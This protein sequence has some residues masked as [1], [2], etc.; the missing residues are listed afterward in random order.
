MEKLS[1]RKRLNI[2]KLY[3]SGLSYRDIAAKVTVSTGAVANVITDL[4]AGNY[5]E[6][7]DVSDQVE[8]LKELA[9]EVTKSGITIGEAMTG[10]TVVSSLKE[11]GLEPTDIPR[12]VSLYKT[13]APTGAET[14][15]FVKAA[16]E[17]EK[18]IQK[19]GL[20]VEDLD[21]KVKSLEEASNRMEPMAAKVLELQ[22]EI[23]QME[24]KKDNLTDEVAEFE[25]RQNVLAASVQEKEQREGDISNRI[26]QLEHRLQSDDERLTIARKDLKTLSE[27]GISL[28]ELSG[29][30]ERLKGVAHRHDIDPKALY[31]RLLTELEQLDKGLKLE[32][33]ILK[34][35]SELHKLEVAISKAEEKLTILS[36]QNQQLRQEIS[37]LKIQ[38]ADERE[39]VSTE[40]EAITATAHNT[41]LELRQDLGKGVRESLN[42]VANLKNEALQTGREIGQL[43][44][45]IGNTTWLEDIL[46]LMKGEDQFNEIKV[47]VVIL[48]MLEQMSTWLERNYPSDVNLYMLKTT[49][50][51][52]ILELQKWK[53]KVNPV[54]DSKNFSTN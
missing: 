31:N 35:R 11:L 40:L 54:G 27:I 16:I 52:L 39:K 37:S 25:K 5:P 32:T 41:V 36:S 43:E 47:R 21:K 53:P 45:R 10:V 12:C 22:E 8:M 13:L 30:A 14:Q 1:L 28:T 48:Q 2:I 15:A 49:I 44:T 34:K 9:A 42:E 19:T 26:A 3:F 33:L 6:L 51:N 38:I 17:F 24:T 29:I 4:K 18:I 7:G 46:S 50:T 20:S 23:E